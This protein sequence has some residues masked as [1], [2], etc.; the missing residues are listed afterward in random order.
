[1]VPMCGAWRLKAVRRELGGAG[2][3]GLGYCGS[4]VNG[5]GSATGGAEKLSHN[6]IFPFG[7]L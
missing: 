6:L 2:A 4:R 3:A 1:V 5:G 7:L